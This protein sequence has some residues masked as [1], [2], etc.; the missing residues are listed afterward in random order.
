MKNKTNTVLLSLILV[1]ALAAAVFTG[2]RYFND[3]SSTSYKEDNDKQVAAKLDSCYKQVRKKTD[4]QPEIAIVLGSGLGDFAK[5]IKVKGHP[6]A[7]IRVSLFLRPPHEA[8][9]YGLSETKR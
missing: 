9:Y 5:R 2:L 3:S 8:I 6:Y 1:C 4:F 7:D